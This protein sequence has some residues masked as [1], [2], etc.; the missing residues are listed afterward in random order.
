MRTVSGKRCRENQNTHFMLNKIFPEIVPFMRKCGKI[1]WIRTG[2]SWQY[3]S[4]H[5]LLTLDTSGYKHTLRVCNTY[6]F[7]MAINVTR[8]RPSIVL[9]EDCLSW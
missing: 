9:Y 1:L 6:C 2:H 5:A 7:C 8:T 4:E 3:S